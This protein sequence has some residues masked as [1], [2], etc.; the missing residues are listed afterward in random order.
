MSSDKSYRPAQPFRVDQLGLDFGIR[1]FDYL[2]QTVCQFA[3]PRFR[4]AAIHRFWF[5]LSASDEQGD[6]KA[7]LKLDDELTLG[8][9][10]SSHPRQIVASLWY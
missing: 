7:A 3:L 10:R 8:A 6:P 9:I 5:P 1:G 2:L 4:F